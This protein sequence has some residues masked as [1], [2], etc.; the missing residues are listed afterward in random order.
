MGGTSV[1]NNSVSVANNETNTLDILE[2]LKGIVRHIFSKDGVCLR[3]PLTN[4]NKKSLVI[5]IT[6][7]L[8]SALLAPRFVCYIGTKTMQP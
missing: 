8:K 3:M 1:S 6:L 7:T 5:L 2:F 4:L